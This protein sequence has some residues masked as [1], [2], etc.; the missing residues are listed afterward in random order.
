MEK[1]GGDVK[2]QD[3]RKEMTCPAVKKN[4]REEGERETS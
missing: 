1:L 2:I 3:R 4:G